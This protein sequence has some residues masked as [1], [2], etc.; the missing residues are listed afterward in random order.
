MGDKLTLQERHLL[1]CVF[2]QKRLHPE[3]Q[4]KYDALDDSAMKGMF[5]RLFFVTYKCLA[6]LGVGGRA[7]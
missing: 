4:G 6:T 2:K 5:E 7:Y 3:Q 1:L